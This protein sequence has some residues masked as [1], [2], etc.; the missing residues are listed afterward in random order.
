MQFEN[1]LED[2]VYA[3]ALGLLLFEPNESDFR[4]TEANNKG[5]FLGRM[6][7]RFNLKL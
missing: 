1:S 6:G 5:G 2:P 7:R 3:C 4:E